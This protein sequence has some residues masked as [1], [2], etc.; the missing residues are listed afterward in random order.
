MVSFSLSLSV[1]IRFCIA[2]FLRFLRFLFLDSLSASLGLATDCSDDSVV[3]FNMFH[4]Y[5][6]N[7]SEV[8]RNQAKSEVG[9]RKSEVGSRKSEVGSRKSE[10]GSLKSEVGSRKSDVPPRLS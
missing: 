2:F 4:V 9:S 5:Y 1:I 8:S 7:N 6:N 3:L 10:V